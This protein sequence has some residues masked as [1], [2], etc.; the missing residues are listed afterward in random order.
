MIGEKVL[1]LYVTRFGSTERISKIKEDKKYE[2]RA[3]S[4]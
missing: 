3:Y 4:Y 1:I 2:E